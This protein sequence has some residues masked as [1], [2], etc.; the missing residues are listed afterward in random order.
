MTH[1]T[2]ALTPFLLPP[3]CHHNTNYRNLRAR[4]QAAGVCWPTTLRISCVR[5]P[6]LNRPIH[7]PKSICMPPKTD[8]HDPQIDLCYTPKS[9]YCDLEIALR[10][11]MIRQCEAIPTVMSNLFVL[12]GVLIGQTAPPFVKRL[13]G[14]NKGISRP[15]RSAC[16]QHEMHTRPRTG[17]CFHP[18]RP[19]PQ[20]CPIAFRLLTYVLIVRLLST[21]TSIFRRLCSAGIFGRRQLGLCSAPQSCTS[22]QS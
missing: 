17:L 13:G 14:V 4:R 3:H 19:G 11:A 9:T 16:G 10:A 18:S 12:V 6:S 22:S 1:F 20:G 8:Q 7:H 2:A 21:Q 5:F 15:C